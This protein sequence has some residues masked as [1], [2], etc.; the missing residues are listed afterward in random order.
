MPPL[1]CSIPAIGE[2]L[3]NVTSYEI[4]YTRAPARMKG[5]VYAICLSSTAVA[6]IVA[7]AAA[8]AIQDPYLIWPYV[9]LAVACFVCAFVFPTY[10]RHL[11]DPVRDFADPARQA[12]LYQPG[13]AAA[14]ANQDAYHESGAEEPEPKR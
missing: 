12:G 14:K 3:V 9:A 5:L 2:I 1:T 8:P 10:Y 6:N 13:V 4:A 11:N 7:L